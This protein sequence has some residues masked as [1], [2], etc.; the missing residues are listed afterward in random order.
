MRARE[1]RKPAGG[2]PLFYYQIRSKDICE[3]F[4]TQKI[5]AIFA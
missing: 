2:G 4:V 1:V 5:L 3:Y